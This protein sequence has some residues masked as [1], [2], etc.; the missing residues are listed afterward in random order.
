MGIACHTLIMYTGTSLEHAKPFNYFGP[1]F[2]IK[3]MPSRRHRGEE[4]LQTSHS[5]PAHDNKEQRA[6]NRNEEIRTLVQLM[7]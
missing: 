3:G 1:S 2:Y 5:K 7:I 6:S 4:I